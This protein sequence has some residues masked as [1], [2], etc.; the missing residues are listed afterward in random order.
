MAIFGRKPAFGLKGLNISD[1]IISNL[2][3]EDQLLE[4]LG[5]NP[6][7]DTTSEAI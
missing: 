4:A 3:T 1:D 2:D 7:E 5:L 6:V